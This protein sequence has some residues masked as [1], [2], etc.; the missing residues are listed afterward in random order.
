MTSPSN[1]KG[2][3]PGKQSGSNLFGKQF[4]E[5]TKN[6]A[7]ED[8]DIDLDF[9][10]EESLSGSSM[11]V[12]EAQ[13][14]GNLT[15]LSPTGG[16]MTLSS[17]SAIRRSDISGPSSLPTPFL[18]PSDSLPLH[19]GALSRAFVKT[20]GRLGRWKRVLNNRSS[21]RTP[22]GSCTDLSAFDVDA[23]GNEELNQYMKTMATQSQTAAHSNRLASTAVRPY[24]NTVEPTSSVDNGDVSYF[25]L[26][27]VPPFADTDSSSVSERDNEEEASGRASIA[28]VDSTSSITSGSP[29]ST[30]TSS[31]DSLG[32]PIANIP[33]FESP[34]QFDVVSIDDLDLSDSSSNDG[35]DGP[36]GL[37]RPTR[38]LPLRRD[39]EFVPRPESVSTM[40]VGSH[41]SDILPENSD[42]QLG[43]GVAEWQLS[44]LVESLSDDEEVGDV[45]AALRRLEGQ[46]NP[47]RR[48]EKALK[49][50]GWVRVMRERVANGDF[51]EDL[52]NSSDEDVQSA[53]EDGS[54]DDSQ[55]DSGRSGLGVDIPSSRKTFD[56]DGHYGTPTVSSGP[57]SGSMLPS[58]AKEAKPPPEPAIPAEIL[59]SRLTD[60]ESSRSPSV[61]LP[62]WKQIPEISKYHRSYI[63]GYRAEIL[64]QHFAMIDRELFLGL[65]FEELILDDWRNCD[66]IDVLD[67]S[68]Y[69]KD[70]ESWRATK[71]WPEKRS[72]LA[73]VRARFN[74]MAN[75]TISEI[76]LSQPNE[77]AHVV[78]K[79]LRIAWVCS[80]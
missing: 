22:V 15:L 65:K 68:Q 2:T 28:S 76:V 6:D 74:V 54:E 30:H 63:L 60:P 80:P 71:M 61:S 73:V 8:S 20:V 40:S 24:Q 45:E 18:Q 42:V 47:T 52:P 77:R 27:P 49:V 21:A 58:Q 25:P 70:R 69:L 5:A 67:W 13:G 7:T 43:Q 44:A 50:D 19:H 72:A 39:F 34:Y 75:F 33:T 9:N 4:A 23:N 35:H 26:Q 64:A 38:K 17:L 11:S 59:E 29:S 12:S 31:T 78:A 48:K 36:P 79:F 16:P 14:G 53:Y 62:V 3:T 1:S 41:S 57:F 51:G 32:Q 66:E 55:S 10:P 56:E 46:I 37:R